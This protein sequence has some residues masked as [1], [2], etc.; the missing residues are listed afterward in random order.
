MTVAI[1][2]RDGTTLHGRCWPGRQA[3]A[4]LVIAHGVGEH[5]G[6]YDHVARE[7]SSRPELVDVLAF[8]F[9]GHG[10]SPGRRGVVRLYEDLVTDLRAAL[11]WSAR[12][13]PGRPRFV[14]GHSNGGQVA[15]RATLDD[16]DAIAGLVLSNPSLALAAR[17]P[18]WKLALGHALRQFAP[19]M[20]LPAGL[21]QAQMTR[22]EAEWASRKSDPWRHGRISAPLF[23]GMV[24]GGSRLLAAAEAVRSPILMLLGANDPVIDPDTSRVFFERLGSPDKTLRLL[25]GTRHEP[26]ND[27]GRD[28]VIDE[29]AAW[30]ASRVPGRS[31]PIPPQKAAA[32]EAGSG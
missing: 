31:V 16:G 28:Q 30:L 22:D 12:T 4:V 24:E 29:I 32:S 5:S 17:V 9:R 23:F 25:P 26:L 11:R 13:W 19:W 14:L 8:D 18:A 2:T 6:C 3:R 7:L 27:L 21:N 10:R 15:L 20:T 1:P